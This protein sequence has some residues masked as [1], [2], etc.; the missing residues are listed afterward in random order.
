[1]R[2]RDVRVGNFFLGEKE[3]G[4]EF[5]DAD[6]ELLVLSASQAATAIANA[7]THRSE[8]R[9]RADREA[10]IETTPVGVVV[11][12]G[13]SG[14]PVSLNRE[15][16]RIVE[17]LRVPG[18]SHEELLDLITCRR[19]D[20]RGA[21]G[22]VLPR[23]EAPVSRGAPPNPRV[24]EASGMAPRHPVDHRLHRDPP[25]RCAST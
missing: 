6:E 7:R 13:S 22:S 19:G 9:A 17:G 25:G 12:D 23:S 5:T 16:R 8:Q 3:G 11:F 18:R 21:R 4:P 20:G 2:H 14:Q 24:G 1:M 10:L 15:V